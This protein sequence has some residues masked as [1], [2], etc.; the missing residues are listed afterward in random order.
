MNLLPT[1]KA[2][3]D[4]YQLLL[5]FQ[6]SRY[7]ARFLFRQ[8]VPFR[9]YENTLAFLISE[10]FPK[11]IDMVI[12]SPAYSARSPVPGQQGRMI[13]YAMVTRMINDLH[14]DV[15]AAEGKDVEVYLDALVQLQ[16]FRQGHS[17]APPRLDLE[18]RRVAGLRGGCCDRKVAITR[19]SIEIHLVFSFSL[20][21]KGLKEAKALKND[22]QT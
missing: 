8:N 11:T 7:R 1:A 19:P 5:I 20:I 22:P 2:H 3:V 14:R 10:K 15:L 16:D 21:I 4:T 13:T 18:N 6:G 9:I 17:L 12:D